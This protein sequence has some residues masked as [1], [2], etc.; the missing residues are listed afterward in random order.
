MTTANTKW[1]LEGDYFEGCNCDSICP[2]IFKGDPD[3]GFCNAT[4]AWHIQKGSYNDKINFNGLNVVALFHTP[5]NMLTGPKWDA[6]L[7]I[8]ERASKE[9]TETGDNSFVRDVD[10]G[11]LQN[12]IRD[13]AA[14]SC[15]AP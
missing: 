2:C 4:A 5:G 3:E 15:Q 13:S 12:Q 1:K 7:Y 9:Q 10:V 14:W 8:D 11:W 6:A